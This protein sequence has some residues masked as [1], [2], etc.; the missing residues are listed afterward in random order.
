MYS[1]DGV[2]L[3]ITIGEILSAAAWAIA[4]FGSIFLGLFCMV[5]GHR[6]KL[7]GGLLLGWIVLSLIL[8]ATLFINYFHSY[9]PPY[10]N[11]IIW[12]YVFLG[13]GLFLFFFRVMVSKKVDTSIE[14]KK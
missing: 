7:V 12:A 10:V 9:P 14:E 4:V 8:F 13:M 5:L 1:T 11:W 3:L 6:R 2:C